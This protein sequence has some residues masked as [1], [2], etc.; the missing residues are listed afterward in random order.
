MK[1]LIAGS[2]SFT[3]YDRLKSILGKEPKPDKIIHGGAKGADSLGGQYAKE[4]NIPCQVVKP[5]WNNYGKKAGYIRNIEMADMLTKDDKAFIFWDGE[6]RGT[7]MMLKLLQYKEIP[8]KL[9]YINS[10]NFD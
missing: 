3:D 7:K 8:F 2:R 9:I 6:S 5:D 4:N 1:W 10:F